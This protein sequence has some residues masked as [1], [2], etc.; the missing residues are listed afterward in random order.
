METTTD[1]W[2]VLQSGTPGLF[3]FTGELQQG[4]DVYLRARWYNAASGTFTSR[5]P[6]AGD[7]QR[8]NTLA[9]YIYAANNPILMTGW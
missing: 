2:G 4:G 5:D 6:W 1:A 7:D 9:L 3:G 8:P